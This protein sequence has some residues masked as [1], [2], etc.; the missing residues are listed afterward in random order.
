MGNNVKQYKLTLDRKRVKEI[1]AQVDGYHDVEIVDLEKLLQGMQ[2]I[3]EQKVIANDPAGNDVS[4]SMFDTFIENL[5]IA[6]VERG[7]TGVKRN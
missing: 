6:T 7:S 1:F 5:I 4:R 3:A 2:F